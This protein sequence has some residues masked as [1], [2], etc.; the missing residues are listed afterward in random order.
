MT[1]DGTIWQKKQ[2][3]QRRATRSK[4]WCRWK[5]DEESDLQG[6]SLQIEQWYSILSITSREN[7]LKPAKNLP[8]FCSIYSISCHF[9]M[10]FCYHFYSKSSR[11][12]L[13]PMYL[14]MSLIYQRQFNLSPKILLSWNSKGTLSCD[15]WNGDLKQDIPV[16]QYL[17]LGLDLGEERRE[18]EYT[19][20]NM[21]PSNPATVTPSIS[22]RKKI[23]GR[24]NIFVRGWSTSYKVR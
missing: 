20:G 2:Q 24:Y 14:E 19:W 8:L 21:C 7:D 15:K 13:G 22:W 18:M 17:F 10:R 6:R 5:E 11:Q 12:R 4:K 23:K 3:V 9:I 16:V 1:K